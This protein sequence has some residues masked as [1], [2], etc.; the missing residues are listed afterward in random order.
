MDLYT[1]LD[2][3]ALECCEHLKLS[4]LMQENGDGEL[5]NLYGIEKETLDLMGES[6]GE[7]AFS[8]RW[9][10]MQQSYGQQGVRQMYPECIGRLPQCCQGVVDPQLCWPQ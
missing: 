5:W 2:G 6:L 7:A 4:D 9:S 1:L 10:G 3:K 8:P